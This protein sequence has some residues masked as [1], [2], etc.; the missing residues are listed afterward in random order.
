MSLERQLIILLNYN[1]YVARSI[2][3][4]RIFNEQKCQV[5]IVINVIFLKKYV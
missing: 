2:K 5:L 3:N 4:Y 1:T